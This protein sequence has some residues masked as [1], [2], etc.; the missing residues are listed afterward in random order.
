MWQKLDYYLN[1]GVQV[2][3]LIASDLG[4][5]DNPRK[6]LK[7]NVKEE[8]RTN[9]NHFTQENQMKKLRQWLHHRRLLWDYSGC[10]KGHI[11]ELKTGE[12]RE[13]LTPPKKGERIWKLDDGTQVHSDE[14][15]VVFDRSRYGYS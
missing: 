14:I 11:L 3:L 9:R 10:W 13:I 15:L 8:F 5:D 6:N 7:L 1:N 12:H 4:V 2:E